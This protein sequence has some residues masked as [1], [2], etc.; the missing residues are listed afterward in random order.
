MAE[1]RCGTGDKHEEMFLPIVT[2]CYLATFQHYESW[3]VGIRIAV[4]SR[5]GAYKTPLISWLVN[6]PH[7]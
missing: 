5:A 7:P 4:T 3:T 2:V 6:Q 1:N